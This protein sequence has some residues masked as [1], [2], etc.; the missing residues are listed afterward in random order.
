MDPTHSC[1]RPEFSTTSRCDSH[2]APVDRK[3]N[4]LVSRATIIHRNEHL[5]YAKSW[6]LQATGNTLPKQTRNPL[7]GT[8]G[9]DRT[10][11]R[12]Q[13]SAESMPVG[14]SSQ[15]G[16]FR[17]GSWLYLSELR[18]VWLIHSHNSALFFFLLNAE[19]WVPGW[20]QVVSGPSGDLP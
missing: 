6:I 15:L 18:W 14:R 10:I 1:L 17:H 11:N 5:V 2:L 13:G 20:N 3:L 12:F 19:L 9:L 8:T 7:P 4:T 16:M